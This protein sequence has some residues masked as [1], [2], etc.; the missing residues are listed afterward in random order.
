MGKRAWRVTRVGFVVVRSAFGELEG[1][2]AGGDAGGGRVERREVRKVGGV[3]RGGWEVGGGIWRVWG[4]GMRNVGAEE[5]WWWWWMLAPYLLHQQSN[6][7][8]I[9]NGVCYEVYSYPDQ[10]RSPAWVYLIS[11][12]TSTYVFPSRAAHHLRS[13]S[14][15]PSPGPCIYLSYPP[16][17]FISNILDVMYIKLGYL[18]R[19]L[20][21]TTLFPFLS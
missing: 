6:Y 11:Q 7:L 5:I 19:F 3:G 20:K 15:N 9:Q 16:V 13:Q 10:V 8:S 12:D 18:C 2:L 21:L 4:C 14:T 1:G 17:P